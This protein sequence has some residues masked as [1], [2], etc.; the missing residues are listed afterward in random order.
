MLCWLNLGW[1]SL[2]LGPV[3]I[4]QTKLAFSF[5]SSSSW[6]PAQ[7]THIATFNENC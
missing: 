1:K 2:N 6:G 4:S 5:M 7:C 3:H